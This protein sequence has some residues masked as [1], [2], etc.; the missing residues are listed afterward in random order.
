MDDFTLYGDTYE[1]SLTNLEIIL[2]RCKEM[3]ISLIHEK[4]FMLINQR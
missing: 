1:E 3:S 2:Q 4:L